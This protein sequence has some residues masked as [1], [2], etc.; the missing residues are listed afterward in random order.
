[1]RTLFG[2]T[3][4][5]LAALPIFGSERLKMTE[6]Q[7]RVRF[8]ETL[9]KDLSAENGADINE[10][11]SRI[12]HNIFPDRQMR[13]WHRAQK[14]GAKY[15]ARVFNDLLRQPGVQGK[16]QAFR[17]MIANMTKHFQNTARESGTL[18]V[19]LPK[20]ITFSLPP[21]VF[22]NPETK[23]QESV[24]NFPWSQNSVFDQLLDLDPADAMKRI[25]ALVKN[26][27][28]RGEASY[29]VDQITEI[30]TE[31]LLINWGEYPVQS[32]TL[33]N[34]AY[35]YGTTLLVSD[36]Q[37]SRRRILSYLRQKDNTRMLV[38]GLTAISDIAVLYPEY[39][40]DFADV[41]YSFLSHKDEPV[42]AW[43]AHLSFVIYVQWLSL[44]KDRSIK[45]PFKNLN[46]KTIKADIP[47]DPAAQVCAKTARDFIWFAHQAIPKDSKDNV[48]SAAASY[49]ASKV[50]DANAKEIEIDGVAQN[51]KIIG[52]NR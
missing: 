19:S 41:A 17:S 6:L 46:E 29:R 9:L 2:L 40:F 36:P 52:L 5:M 33:L 38:R 14:Y 11:R 51:G 21:G 37:V 10:Q 18:V 24:R 23:I 12:A 22:L 35:L 7:R 16:S 8:C 4:S 3:L 15:K 49:S 20:R 50:Q 34:R 25:A 1:M 26:W 32:T 48:T 42:R 13:A 44:S 31:S 39:A 47:V 45:F 27:Q 30:L 43:A 28:K